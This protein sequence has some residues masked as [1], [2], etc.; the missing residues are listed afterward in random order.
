MFLIKKNK[1]F[2]LVSILFSV[3]VIPE[4]AMMTL[5]VAVKR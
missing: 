1:Q 2:Q 3:K 5:L 4:A